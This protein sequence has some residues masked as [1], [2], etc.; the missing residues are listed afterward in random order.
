M[1]DERT[2]FIESLITGKTI[3]L[4]ID[5]VSSIKHVKKM[6]QDQESIPP[7]QQRLVFGG[8]LLEDSRT[9]SYY[10]IVDCNTLQ[11]ARTVIFI[12]PSNDEK[13]ILH[14]VNLTDTIKIVKQKIQDRE[15]TPPEQQ[16]LTY[17]GEKLED[18]RHLCDYGID[19]QCTIMLA[20]V[21]CPFQISV[22]IV[23]DQ[24]ITR[25]PQGAQVK[26]AAEVQLPKLG[27]WFFLGSS[28]FF[29]TWFLLYQ[30]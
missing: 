18:R 6:I 17:S 22:T 29:Q 20:Y 28:W 1:G 27:S 30:V 23:D 7:D 12:K 5:L 26:L 8:E 21:N 14:N 15:G 24:I 2:I 9:L 19:D 25:I 3:T 4:W 10:C 11:L 16:S 13:Y